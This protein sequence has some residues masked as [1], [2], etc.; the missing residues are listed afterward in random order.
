MKWKYCS[1]V[2]HPPIFTVEVEDTLP[3]KAPHSNS[4]NSHFILLLLF[5]CLISRDVEEYLQVNLCSHP[6]LHIANVEM[7]VQQSL[8][9]KKEL[10]CD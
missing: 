5:F 3:A 8:E 2:T 7:F 6:L 4:A 10:S 9:E 1:A